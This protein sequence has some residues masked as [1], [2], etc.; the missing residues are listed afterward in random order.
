[1]GQEGSPCTPSA[2]STNDIT[3][4]RGPSW[5]RIKMLTLDILRSTR[6]FR[7]YSKWPSRKLRKAIY[8]VISACYHLIC[9]LLGA[10]HQ[11]L[12]TWNSFLIFKANTHIFKCYFQDGHH[13]ETQFSQMFV[14]IQ[15]Y[16]MIL[17]DVKFIVRWI[18]RSINYLIVLFLPL[19]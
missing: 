10:T 3:L 4:F 17:F 2:T 19:I 9:L 1:M 15:T 18:W 11:Y 12:R 5:L 7:W 13:F 6:H 16:F 14:K 8:S